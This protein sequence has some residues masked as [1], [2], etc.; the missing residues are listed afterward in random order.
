MADRSSELAKIIE[1]LSEIQ[2]RLTLHLPERLRPYW[3]ELH[4]TARGTLVLGARGT[5]KTTFI[6]RYFQQKRVLFVP[7]DSPLVA[8]YT[9]WEIAESTFAQGYEGIVFDEVHYGKDWSLHLK[10]I[11]DSYPKQIV[12]ASD[13]SSSIWKQSVAD[14]SR[15]FVKIQIPLLSFR[16]YIYLSQGILLPKLDL[17]SPQPD[18]IQEIIKQVNILA[19]FK[20]YLNHGTRPI[21][22]EGQYSE[23]SL[24]ILEKTLFSDLPFFV[25]QVHENHFRVLKSILNYLAMS[26]IPRLNLEKLCKEWQIGKEKLYQLLA[27]AEQI[28]LIRVIRHCG[29][30][31]N[32]TRG[33][34][35]FLYDPTHYAALNGELGN[36]RESFA[37]CILQETGYSVCIPKDDQICDFVANTV[38]IEIG[39]KNKP[40]KQSDFVIR[41][42]IDIPHGKI[43]PLWVLG[44][45][46]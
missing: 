13:S 3:G 40:I 36:L 16:E 8:P 45:G 29:T 35:I 19:L 23:R 26:T 5:G 21:F 17:F 24:N 38:K 27:V 28:H 46:Y 20:D 22:Q 34:K 7:V 18:L 25:P 31:V 11:Y 12:W 33:A 1:K 6:L 42:D 37:A 4:P 14:L 41:D 9:L 43:I 15:R 44:M 10:A 30:K 2:A 39:G 32:Q